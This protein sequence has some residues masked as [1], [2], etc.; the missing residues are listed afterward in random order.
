MSPY[1]RGYTYSR[2]TSGGSGLLLLRPLLLPPLL[3][4]LP[5]LL[6]A[7]LQAT[8]PPPM[9]LHIRLPSLTSASHSSRFFAPC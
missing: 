5:L 8:Q 3:P 4:M 6:L 2:G 9:T 1:L 7:G